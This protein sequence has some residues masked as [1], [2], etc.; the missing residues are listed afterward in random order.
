MTRIFSNFGVSHYI[1]PGYGSGRQNLS[2]ENGGHSHATDGKSD[3]FCRW[4][5]SRY[6]NAVII[7]VH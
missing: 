3:D 4:G 5:E 1:C 7:A 6:P 2:L